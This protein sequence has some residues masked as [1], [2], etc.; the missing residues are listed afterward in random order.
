MIPGSGRSLGGG[1]GNPLQYSCLENPMDRGAWRAA[2]YEVTKNQ[3]QLKW[4]STHTHKGPS[5]GLKHIFARSFRPVPSSPQQQ[6]SP[7]PS[8]V[9]IFGLNAWIKTHQTPGRGGRL[10]TPRGGGRGCG[11]CR[12][13]L[14][15]AFE[16]HCTASRPPPKRDTWLDWAEQWWDAA[17]ASPSRAPGCVRVRAQQP[18]LPGREGRWSVQLPVSLHWFW[19]WNREMV[20]FLLWGSPLWHPPGPSLRWTEEERQKPVRPTS[21]PC[22]R[23]PS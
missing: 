23:W 20:P 21:I 6:V 1:H 19:I 5:S 3:I 18:L 11:G 7:L 14:R 17:F 8:A 10:G 9:S 16:S 2:V 13:G 22:E 15:A 12:P 4:L